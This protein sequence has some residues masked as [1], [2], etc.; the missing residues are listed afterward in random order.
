MKIPYSQ[1]LKFIPS[2]PSMNEISEKLFQLG[3]EHEIND[4]IFDM[5]F[6]P[7]RGDCLSLD[8][9]LRDLKVFYDI[10]Q[11]NPTYTKQ[12][13]K[14]EF[15]FLN[16][17]NN[18]CPYIS[19]LKIN[20]DNNIKEYSGALKEYFDD[21]NIKKNNFFTD[22]SNFILYETGQPTHCYDANKIDSP[23]K[24]KFIEGDHVFET[25]LDKEITLTDKNL[26]FVSNNEVVN[27]AGIMGG[28]SS[29]CS[30]DTR[31]VLIECAF[32]N[33]ED[34]IGKALKYALTSD[35]AHKY[36]R[37]VDPLCHEKVLRRFIKIIEEHTD[38]L[39]I[40]ICQFKYKN[41]EKVKFK[42]DFKKAND[43]LGIKISKEEYQ[44]YISRLGF[45]FEDDYIVCPSYRSDIKNMN[46]IAE[47]IA[48]V[49]GYNNIRSEPLTIPSISSTLGSSISF[50]NKLK[51]TLIGNGFYEVIN[52]PFGKGI[53]LSIKVDNPLDSNREYLRT[54]LKNSLLNNLLYNERRQKLSVKL[55]EFS[56]IYW[57]SEGNIQK[58]RSLGIICSGIVGKN[59]LDFS[60]K[61]DSNYLYRLLD[62][63]L[64]K[65][66]N[67]VITISR[68]N[69]QT[70]KQD[71]IVYLEIEINQLLNNE[72]LEK[73]KHKEKNIIFKKYI[74]ISEFPFSSRDLSFS[75][76][77][78]SKYYD[79]QKFVLGFKN[80]LLKEVFVFDF[81]KDEKNEV[82]KL[83]FRFI[84]QSS[85]STV[86]EDQVNEVMNKIIS[87][88]LAID[89]VNIPGLKNLKY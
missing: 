59:Y 5:E 58:K 41:F 89:S 26:A 63:F 10:N 23:L 30:N 46:D 65:N 54:D 36:E 37:G 44:D 34:I 48:R 2:A 3:H 11:N 84:F 20:I 82:I 73:I 88:C 19:F 81:Y 7:N 78:P 31:S 38:I 72:S 71:E 39:S 55:F 14:F 68:E 62:D 1:L 16:E 60:R 35:A 70:K 67:K 4:G 61:I 87:H 74:P 52:N 27:L 53:D 29:A 13:D 69:I 9:L 79:L 83:G 32:F 86:T 18:A 40:N 56:D 51:D 49:V 33:P 45:H 24:L 21:L 25:L 64:P 43:I 77:D 15:D 50:E 12:I 85:L 80:K 42:S 6:T 76:D 47:E 8:G 66:D 75:I 22:I 57:L 28:K 17:E